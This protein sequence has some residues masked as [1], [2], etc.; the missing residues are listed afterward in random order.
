MY[1]YLRATLF[2]QRKDIGR[3][4][5]VFHTGLKML[6]GSEAIMIEEAT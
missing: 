5:K 3:K 6:F 4:L 2:L 1:I